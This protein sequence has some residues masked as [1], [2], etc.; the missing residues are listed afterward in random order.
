[1]AEGNQ[2]VFVYGTLRKGGRWNYLLR[3][4]ALVVVDATVKGDLFDSGN[5]PVALPGDGKIVGEVYEVTPKVFA[6][7]DELEGHPKWYVRKLVEIAHRDMAD[8]GELEAWVYWG[9]HVGHGEKIE[10][11]DYMKHLEGM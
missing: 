7:L 3:D 2:F 6:R 11:G 4:S 9:T 10:S 1:M 8:V 5:I